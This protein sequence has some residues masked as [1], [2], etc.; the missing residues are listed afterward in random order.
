MR[1]REGGGEAGVGREGREGGAAVRPA[2]L[3]AVSHS[4][5]QCIH[6]KCSVISAERRGGEKERD[7]SR[8]IKT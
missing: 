8:H 5:T 1:G 4:P 2:T 6:Q 3:G 7:I